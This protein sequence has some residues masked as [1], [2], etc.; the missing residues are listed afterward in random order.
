MRKNFSVYLKTLIKMMRGVDDDLMD[1][2]LIRNPDGRI[3]DTGFSNKVQANVTATENNK[4]SH[5]ENFLEY[6]EDVLLMK[7]PVKKRSIHFSIIESYAS[8]ML[9]IKSFVSANNYLS[10]I[11]NMFSEHGLWLPGQ[12]DKWHRYV[13]LRARVK[14]L[15]PLVPKRAPIFSYAAERLAIQHLKII[16]IRILRVA[17]WGLRPIAL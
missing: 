3:V 12:D 17:L 7:L 16:S 15:S 13:Q 14:K 2:S 8:W 11:Y 5:W 10:T 6:F 4:V 1:P 9:N